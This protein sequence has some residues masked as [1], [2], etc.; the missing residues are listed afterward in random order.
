MGPS[1]SLV[2]LC[3]PRL[4]QGVFV[5]S[6]MASLPEVWFTPGAARAP[7]A[8]GSMRALSPVSMGTGYPT[9]CPPGVLWADTSGSVLS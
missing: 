5:H 6:Q 3:R 2:G 4:F 7:P 9:S 1:E 8:L